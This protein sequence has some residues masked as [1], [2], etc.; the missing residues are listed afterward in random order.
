ML[1]MIEDEPAG[2]N[3]VAAGE[4]HGLEERMGDG[5]T[6]TADENSVTVEEDGD[7]DD[8]DGAVA[9]GELSGDI[10]GMLPA[11]SVDGRELGGDV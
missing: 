10:L 3:A 5:E 2:N 6:V 9:L 8:V 11:A 7:G 4:P 1:L